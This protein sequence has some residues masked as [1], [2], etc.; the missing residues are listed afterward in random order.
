ML[1]VE[2]FLTRDGVRTALVEADTAYTYED[3]SQ[4]DLRGLRIEFFDESGLEDGI[5]TSLSGLYDLESGDLTVR[6][7]VVIEG[8]LEAGSRSRLET[9]SLLYTAEDDRLTTEASWVLSHGDGS[10]ERG[11]GLITDSSLGS[12][13]TRDWS[14]STPGVEVPE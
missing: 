11:V 1:G 9:D 10:V 6:G 3:A 7:Q 2:H 8:Y 5:L 12:I 14:V 13:E 4:V